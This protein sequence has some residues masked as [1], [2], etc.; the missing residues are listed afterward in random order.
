MKLLCEKVAGVIDSVGFC[1]YLL[2][3][4][5]IASIPGKAFGE[6]RCIR[7]SFLVKVDGH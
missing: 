1:D 5:R 2:K 7:L 3:K 4:W 6:D